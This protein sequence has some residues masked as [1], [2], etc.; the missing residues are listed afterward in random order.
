[1]PKVEVDNYTK[2]NIVG[3]MRINEFKGYRSV[4]FQIE[5]YTNAL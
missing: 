3:T 4:V 1:M 2:I 5:K